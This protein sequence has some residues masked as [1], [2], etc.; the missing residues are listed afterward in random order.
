[1]IFVPVSA[2]ALFL[3]LPFHRKIRETLGLRLKPRL[4]PDWAGGAKTLWIHAASG[5]FE[6]AKPLIKKWRQSHPDW[7]IY[8]TYFS[9]TYRRSVENFPG[10]DACGPLPLDL[11][12]PMEHFVR[13]LK[14]TVLAVARTDLW[15]E[16]GQACRRNKIP[17][18]LFSATRSPLK[19]WERWAA[20]ALRWRYQN[21]D[22]ILTVS[23]SDRDQLRRLHLRRPIEALGDTRYDQVIERLANPKPVEFPAARPAPVLIGGST[24]EPDEKILIAASRDLLKTGK[25]SLILVPHEP[26]EPHL[27]SLERRLRAE[28]LESIR[29]SRTRDW[30]GRAVLLVDQVG[31]LAELYTNA[32]L[33]LVGGSFK[34]SVHSVMEPLAAGLVTIVG[35]YHRNNREAIEFQN[36]WISPDMSMV[37]STKTAAELKDLLAHWLNQ[38]DRAQWREKIKAS[39]T[40]RSAATER[41]AAYIEGV[42]RKT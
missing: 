19:R 30:D 32:D 20:F 14:P 36:E 34:R 18:I 1:M 38:K 22:H 35:P 13:K 3:V 16:L 31:I 23:D 24:W 6:Y 37:M 9:P 10:V 21:A 4:W 28:G 8:V 26:T 27:V 2:I 15:P 25:L 11:P 42:I 7:K 41:V 17:V 33:A 5:E 39:V 12:G 40:A 29:F